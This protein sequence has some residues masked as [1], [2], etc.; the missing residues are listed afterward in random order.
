M[1]HVFFFSYARKTKNSS[2][3]LNLEKGSRYNILDLLFEDLVDLVFG[4]VGGDRSKV[5]CKDETDL[6]IGDPWPTILADAVTSAKV[7]VAILTPSYLESENCGREFGVFLKRY[8][9]MKAQY[10]NTMLPAPIVPLY[11]E[12]QMFCWPKVPPD[13][14]KFFESTQF[15]QYGMPEYYPSRG[16]RNIFEISDNKSV[17]KTILYAIRSRIYELAQL[18]LPPLQGVSDF[19]SIPSAF[20]QVQRPNV[21]NLDRPPAD[22]DLVPPQQAFPSIQL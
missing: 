21:P 3:L 1:P 15:T 10:G 18:N 11:F 4:A 7:L 6:A 14:R 2:F 12:D 19:N 20:M 22:L 13:V 5:G 9:I 17:A 16:Y 8:E